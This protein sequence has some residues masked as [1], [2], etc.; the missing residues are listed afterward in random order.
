M[1][2][3]II[4]AFY[5]YVFLAVESSMSLQKFKG[6]IF[7]IFGFE[8]RKNCYAKIHC[9]SLF[10]TTYSTSFFLKSSLNR[11]PTILTTF[12]LCFRLACSKLS[13][14]KSELLSWRDLFVSWKGGSI[15]RILLAC[16]R[17]LFAWRQLMI[18]QKWT[19][20][21][22]AMNTRTKPC[23][24]VFALLYNYS[25]VPIRRHGSINRH[26]SIIRPCPFLIYEAWVY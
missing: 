23:Q 11:L 17:L 19:K 22:L 15:E 18:C 24:I 14:T 4:F 26:I 21:M 13:W 16:F 3:A 10:F 6:Q 5:R 25:L 20:L 12:L 7:F 8:I 2:N 1:H 9:H